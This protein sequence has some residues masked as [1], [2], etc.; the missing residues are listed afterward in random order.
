MDPD[1]PWNAFEA[2]LP[3]QL[4]ADAATGCF[5][6]RLRDQDFAAT[7]QAL[8]PGRQVHGLADDGETGG[9]PGLPGDRQHFAGGYPDGCLLQ[10]AELQAERRHDLFLDGDG[11]AH[12]AQAVV[13]MG[14]WCA[15]DGHHGVAQIPLHDAAER[16]HGG[17][18]LRGVGL[19]DGV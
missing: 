6:H 18:D 16:E 1:P 12:G 10:P 9:M 13:A 11:R 3:Q 19:D 15:E 4:A 2:L 5:V 14:H 8:D 17:F 7:G